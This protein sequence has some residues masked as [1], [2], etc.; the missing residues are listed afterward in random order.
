M[1]WLLKLIVIWLSVDVLIMATSWYA[2]TTIKP[3][4]PNLWRLVIAVNDPNLN[5]AVPAFVVVSSH[6]RYPPNY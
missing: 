4:F 2:V 5:K 3:H 6:R 1:D